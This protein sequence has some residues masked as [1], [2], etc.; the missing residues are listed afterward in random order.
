M[1]CV[2]AK[3]ANLGVTLLELMLATFLAGVLAAI[4]IPSYQETVLRTRIQLA[5]TELMDIRTG[6][7][8]SRGPEFKLPD[9]LD[10]VANIPRTDPWGRPYV[11]L[12][13]KAP[14]VNRGDMRKDR[15]LVPINSEFDLYSKGKDGQSRPPL[16]AKP[17]QDDVV[18]ARDGAYVG[19]AKDF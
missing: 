12:N 11:Y 2:R 4:G 16:P 10:S 8:A 1:R 3:K 15:N 19:L 18:I 13:F 7:L 5:R 6:V 14:G 17:S 9:S